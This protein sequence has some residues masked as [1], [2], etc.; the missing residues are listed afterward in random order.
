MPPTT[1]NNF[2]REV[3]KSIDNPLTFAHRERVTIANINAGYTLLNALRRGKYRL[4]EVQLIAIGGAAAAA[5]AVVIQ[6]VQAGATVSLLSTAI[7]ALTQSAVNYPGL[8]N[9]T[10]LADGASFAPC[11]VNTGITIAKT[12]SALTTATHIDVILVYCIDNF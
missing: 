9:N 7:A 4:V 8:A 11:D 10:I 3:N 1:K 12:G 2:Q 6:G 5:T